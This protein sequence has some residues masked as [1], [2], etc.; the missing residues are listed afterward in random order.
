MSSSVL[1]G[2][3]YG[4]EKVSHSRGQEPWLLG[5]SRPAPAS[6]ASFREGSLCGQQPQRAP[7]PRCAHR[8]S[9]KQIPVG[10]LWRVLPVGDQDCGSERDTGPEVSL[11]SARHFVGRTRQNLS[12]RSR[13]GQ[14]ASPRSHCAEVTSGCRQLCGGPLVPQT[15]KHCDKSKFQQ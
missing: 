5:R 1:S 15:V 3:G 4:G 14:C 12:K 8:T 11:P 6:T 7:S 10:P 13:C 9:A 2:N